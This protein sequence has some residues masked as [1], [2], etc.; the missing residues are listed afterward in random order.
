MISPVVCSALWINLTIARTPPVAQ[1]NEMALCIFLFHLWL[2]VGV[3]SA[4]ILM[5]AMLRMEIEAVGYAK[6]ACKQAGGDLFF[7]SDTFLIPLPES[8]NKIAR[9]RHRKGGRGKFIPRKQVAPK[10][11]DC[12]WKEFTGSIA[13]NGATACKCSHPAVSSLADIKP[14][15]GARANFSGSASHCFVF[16]F[17]HSETHKQRVER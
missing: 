3:A 8:R 5:S 14:K 9:R 1:R 6:S 4:L 15:K 7:A 16:N 2:C 17:E 13:W 10:S 12:I 11:R